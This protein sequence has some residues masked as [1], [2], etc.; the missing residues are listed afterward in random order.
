MAA[1]II[2]ILYEL[3]YKCDRLQKHIENS[4][5]DNDFFNISKQIINGDNVCFEKRN[6]FMT[7]YYQ[8]D[9]IYQLFKEKIITFIN[10]NPNHI[11]ITDGKN[12]GDGNLETFKM[13]DILHTHKNFNKSYDR[14][15]HIRLEDFVTHN[16]YLP[17]DRI[18]NLLDKHIVS[19]DLCIVCKS[20]TTEFEKS[21]IEKIKTYLHLHNITPYLEHN[22]IL[23]DFYIMKEAKTLICSKSTLSWCAAF[24]STTIEHCY[25]PD[26]EIKPGKTTCKR[27]ISNTTLY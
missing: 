2:C 12:A 26:Y 4:I 19:D 10:A 25:L 21:Y 27:P 5:T 16:L 23:T 14:V 22:D 6:Y 17:V 3:E 20:P 7:E 8:H 11:V 1:S 9:E 18:I 13:Y 15:L 24:F